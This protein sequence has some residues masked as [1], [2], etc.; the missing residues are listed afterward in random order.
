[1]ETMLAVEAKD[2]A[3]AIRVFKQKERER[4]YNIGLTNVINYWILRCNKGIEYA[5]NRGDYSCRLAF[6]KIVDRQ[7][8]E[9]FEFYPSDID[10]WM[11]VQTHFEEYGYKVKYNMNSYEMEIDWE[12]IS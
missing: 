4:L 3:E 6:S 8:G 2:K 10:V 1:M 9:L 12:H 5:V 11:P 7:G